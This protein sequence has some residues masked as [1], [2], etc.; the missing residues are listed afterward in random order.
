[1]TP[2]NNLS[3]LVVLLFMLSACSGNSLQPH[4][5]KDSNPFGLNIPDSFLFS[6]TKE[7]QISISAKLPSGQPLARAVYHIWDGHPN[8]GGS[9]LS[10]FFL[11]DNGSLN[12]T[13]EI[14]AHLDEVY[15]STNFIGAAHLTPVPVSGN[16]IHYTHQPAASRAV[17]NPQEMAS[18]SD[19]F[20][21]QPAG[22]LNSQFTPIGEWDL[23]TGR[24]DYLVIPDDLNYDFLE[25]INDVLDG[26]NIAVHR[27]ELLNS[28]IPRDLYL[29]SE[30]QVW[31]TFVHSDPDARYNNALGFYTYTADTK[32]QSMDDID[33]KYIIFPRAR[34]EDGILNAGDK[35]QLRIPGTDGIFPAGTYIGWF[36]VA[37]GW[38]NDGSVRERGHLHTHSSNYEHNTDH[39][40]PGLEEHLVVLY[41]VQESKLVF[42]WEDMVRSANN[43]SSNDFNDLIFYA[44]WTL[45]G[46]VDPDGVPVLPDPNNSDPK[47][48]NYGPAEDRFGTLLFEDLW[49]SYGDYDMND[50]VVSYQ[51]KETANI[52]NNVEEIEFTL[53]IRATGATISSG[54]GFMFDNVPPSNVASVSGNR[55]TSG[56]ITTNGN[57]TENEQQWATIIAFDDSNLNMPTFSNVYPHRAHVDYDTVTVTVTFTNPVPK[58]LLGSSPYNVFSFRTNERS[59]EIHLPG[60]KPSNLAD[61]S[62]FGTRDDDSDPSAGRFYISNGNLNWALNVP[63]QIPYPHENASFLQAYKY[64]GDWA[65]SGGSDHANWYKDEGENR[66]QSA[67]YINPNAGGNEGDEED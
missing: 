37:N 13:L 33:D 4:D 15:I 36:L 17:A 42:G 23:T 44:T 40:D 26:S 52:N 55:L 27:P 30:G 38:H 65:Q 34:L 56:N 16:S 1:M 25:R 57:G 14:P 29:E 63:D 46:A 59:H 53:V 7:A 50:L 45:E 5:E 19:S 12:T 62:K 11:D 2:I 9:R 49:P 18:T 8:E 54:L 67:L 28:T 21:N 60:R 66:N 41:D 43:R 48:Y 20:L 10:S 32:P 24:P 6:S 61:T 58:M 64:F 35:V 22:L 31:V 3:A 39:S 51:S 47:I